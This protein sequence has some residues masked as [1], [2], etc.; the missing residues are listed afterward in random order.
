MKIN[1]KQIKLLD[2]T[3]RDGGYYTNWEFTPEL[4]KRY[5]QAVNSL[6]IDYV[7]LGYRS[8]D[9][10][11]YYG[12]YYYLPQSVLTQC[13]TWCPNARLAL[14]L[15]LKEVDVES[16][17]PLLENI[18]SYVYMIRMATRPTDISKA[19]MIARVAK[20]YGLKVSINVMYM[21]EWIKQPSF[22]AELQGAESLLDGM[23]MVDS[24]GAVYPQDIAPCVRAIK[25]YYNGTIGFHGHDN[26]ELAFANTLAAI[27]A[28]VDCVDATMLGMGR[29]AGNLKTELLLTYLS[30]LDSSISLNT[31][32]DTLSDF[33]ALKQTYKWGTNLPYMISGRYSLPQK[34][35]MAWVTQKRY[36]AAQIVQRLQSNVISKCESRS[37]SYPILEIRKD[38]PVVSILIGGGDSVPQHING[39]LELIR[40]ECKQ[41]PI[42][43]VFSSSKHLHLFDDMPENVSRYIYMVG[44]EGR[45]LERQMS[46]VR[47]QDILVVTDQSTIDAYIPD[48]LISQTYSL[49]KQVKQE[50]IIY[51]DSPLCAAVRIATYLR[52]AAIWMV[53]FDGYNME[54]KSGSY[55]L[56][57]ETQ[58]VIDY[59]TKEMPLYTLLPTKYKHLQMKPL[60]SLL[61]L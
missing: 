23:V 60:Y 2:C 12:Q 15:N 13:A 52:T 30:S 4:V 53:G 29:G 35:I 43:L 37:Q 47:K 10:S 28:G 1:G 55:D 38:C 56:M 22:A 44:I 61:S 59:L 58:T 36:S 7:E 3:L 41:H 48:T 24:Y 5:L 57:M 17:V 49:G 33:E 42:Q 21:S 45:R 54:D 11:T 26:M 19:K 39:I 25:K 31:L 34:E 27:E 40:K 8:P 18:S 6:P 14:M 32:M 9:V 46:S 51:Q 50:E 20:D 16:V